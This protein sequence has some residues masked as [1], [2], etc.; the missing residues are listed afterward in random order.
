[1]LLAAGALLRPALAA[2]AALRGAGMAAR[3]AGGAGWIDGE[4]AGDRLPAGALRG[5]DAGWLRS[6][7]LLWRGGGAWVAGRPDVTGAVDR[8]GALV[9]AGARG[10]VAGR[11]MLVEL[12]EPEVAGCGC[13]VAGWVLRGA[14]AGVGADCGTTERTP[15]SIE[16]DWLGACRDVAGAVLRLAP[17]SRGT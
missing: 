12:P 5:V 3:V 13:R 17:A 4:G 6:A 2:G 7:G 8:A 11:R 14:G 10:C 15:G 1:M 9:V 16:R